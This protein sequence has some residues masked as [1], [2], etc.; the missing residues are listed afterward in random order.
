LA[1]SLNIWVFL[2]QSGDFDVF[3][4]QLSSAFGKGSPQ[5]FLDVG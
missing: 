3:D 1:I 2:A 4:E 5:N